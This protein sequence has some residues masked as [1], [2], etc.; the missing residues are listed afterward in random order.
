[1]GAWAPH[2]LISCFPLSTTFLGPSG[3]KEPSRCFCDWEDTVLTYG[4]SPSYRETLGMKT[5]SPLFT[6]HRE[7]M[8][9]I[10]ICLKS[11]H[12]RVFR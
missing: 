8:E 4:A 6:R 2:S 11:P 1:M 10:Y 3:S 12:K 7:A 9:K 5:T